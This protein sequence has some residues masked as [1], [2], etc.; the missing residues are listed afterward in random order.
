[1]WQTRESRFRQI[2][3]VL[4]PPISHHLSLIGSQSCQADMA[5]VLRNIDTPWDGSCCR[6]CMI[7]TR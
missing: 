3:Y 1:M 7:F 5:K 2:K 4:E 6:T